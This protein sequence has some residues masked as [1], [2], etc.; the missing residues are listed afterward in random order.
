MRQFAVTLAIQAVGCHPAANQAEP[1]RRSPSATRVEPLPATGER[2][3]NAPTTPSWL[4]ASPLDGPRADLSDLEV[5]QTTGIAPNVRLV[6]QRSEGTRLDMCRLAIRSARRWYVAHAPI[7]SCDDGGVSGA[8][9]IVEVDERDVVRGGD[10]ELVLKVHTRTSRPS[11]GR[12]ES[13][14]ADC[15][16][17]AMVLCATLGIQ[18]RCTPPIPVSNR[19]RRASRAGLRRVETKART[20]DER[21]LLEAD[22]RVDVALPGDGTL[23]ISGEVSGFAVGN[24][25]TG[26]WHLDL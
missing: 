13:N 5:E 17:E 4:S 16:T 22:W 24:P 21:G 18:P 6:R 25:P 3:E 23:V 2:A 11:M 26:T 14:D 9:E 7:G 1:V 20:D 8:I 19:C 12:Y 15:E 10:A